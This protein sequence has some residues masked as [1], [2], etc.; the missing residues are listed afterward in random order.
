MIPSVSTKAGV[1]SSEGRF[2]LGR[3]Y[4]LHLPHGPR[5]QGDLYHQGNLNKRVNL[6]NKA[7]RR[8]LIVELLQKNLNQ[9]RLAE[10]LNLSRQTLHNYRESY[11][12][13]GVS[14]LLHGYSPNRCESEK[15]QG[16]LRIGKRRGGASAR[17]REGLRHADAT[18]LARTGEE[19]H[20]A[21]HDS[22]AVTFTLEESA[23]ED[24]LRADQPAAGLPLATDAAGVQ[25]EQ[26]GSTA[27]GQIIDPPYAETHDWLASRHAG[28]FP[29]LLVLASRHQ[30]FAH[31]LGLFPDNWRIFHLF[32]LMAV[33]D[34]RSFAALEREPAD[35]AGRILGLCRLPGTDGLWRWFFEAAAAGRAAALLSASF[36]DRIRRGL[37]GT[38]IWFTEEHALPCPA[39]ADVSADAG[40]AQARPRHRQ[41]SLVTYDER[42]RIVCFAIGQGADKLSCQILQL[43]EQ[44]RA[45]SLGILPVQVFTH[46][47]VASGFLSRLVLAGVPFVARQESDER[48]MDVPAS[49]FGERLQFGSTAYRVAEQTIALL[50]QAPNG[51]HNDERTL[52]PITLRRLVFW[53]Q[54]SQLRC[55]VLCWDAGLRLSADLLLCAAVARRSAVD[56]AQAPGDAA[57]RVGY[58]PG[59][60]EGEGAPRVI[61]NPLCRVLADRINASEGHLAKLHKQQAQTQP[62]FNQDGSERQNSRHRRLS[63][64]I[65]ASEAALKRLLSEKEGLPARITVT[66]LCDY[67]SQTAIDNDGKMLFDFVTSSVWNV[68]HQLLDWLFDSVANNLN[69]RTVLD[70]ILASPGWIRSDGQAVVVRLP[71]LPQAALRYAQEH[72]C[73]RLSGLGGRLPDGRALHL[74]VGQAPA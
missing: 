1:D 41:S 70:T 23:I 53:N 7:E 64:A 10:V 12:V 24:V 34:W 38:R 39:S 56:A 45:L 48:L 69:R 42:G 44:A 62:S 67:R 73:R 63:D 6:A 30:W 17:E 58:Q 55:S 51:P 66:G 20:P 47:D 21:A 3:G 50:D 29:V 9:T 52:V 22:T 28:V 14:G 25:S 59:F 49:S 65:S 18:G 61:A 16:R 13:F 35:E 15:M 72:L 54:A 36:A 32:V 57:R 5:S 68:R 8:I 74:E 33:R 43:A 71:P 26:P 4:W 11:R 46:A 19:C 60:A 31:L 40:A 2:D 27:V 37:V